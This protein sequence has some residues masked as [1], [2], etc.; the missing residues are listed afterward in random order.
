MVSYKLQF[1]FTSMNWRLVSIRNRKIFLACNFIVFEIK[2][3]FRVER[4]CI[5]MFILQII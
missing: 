2:A 5:Y 3:R 1:Y 4:H